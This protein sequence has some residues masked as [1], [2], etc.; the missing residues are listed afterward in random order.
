MVTDVSIA[1]VE[2]IITIKWKVIV[3]QMYL[4]RCV[5]TDW[6]VLL[7][8]YWLEDSS[9]IDQSW[10]GWFG[11]V[12]EVRSFCSFLMLM[13]WMSHLYGAR[14]VSLLKICIF[15]YS[16]LWSRVKQ[17][18]ISLPLKQMRRMLQEALQHGIIQLVLRTVMYMIR[19][20]QSVKCVDC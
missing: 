19:Y 1:W 15:L 16:F 17:V 7:W 6:S 12:S 13:S 8:C 2:V 4:V 3:S 14:N 18:V 10:C 11:S 9:S 20:F 5:K